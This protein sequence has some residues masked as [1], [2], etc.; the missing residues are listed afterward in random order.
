M[1]IVDNDQVIVRRATRNGATNIE[2]EIEWKKADGTSLGVYSVSWRDTDEF[3]VF[4][5]GQEFD[6]VI[7]AV[8]LQC[9]NQTT[10]ALRPTVFDALAGK[11]FQVQT[12]VQQV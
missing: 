3:R 11:T 4:L 7:R 5:E 12:K 2:I 8:M 1:P 6:D 9:L 10:G